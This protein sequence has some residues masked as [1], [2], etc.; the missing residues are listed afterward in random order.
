M[1]EQARCKLVKRRVGV[2]ADD[3]RAET[4]CLGG[5]QTQLL[6]ELVDAIGLG[7]DQAVLARD[8]AEEG[9]QFEV[10]EAVDFVEELFVRHGRGL[11]GRLRSSCRLASLG[12]VWSRVIDP[13]DRQATSSLVAQSHGI[14]DEP[15]AGT[16]L[17]SFHF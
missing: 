2:A 17:S 13:K 12:Q 4:E 7:T 14:T 15:G 16:G 5:D 6:G 10:A 3:G 11:P 1:G 8:E 9:C